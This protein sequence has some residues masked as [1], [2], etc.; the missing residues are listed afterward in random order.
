MSNRKI[1]QQQ[2]SAGTTVDADRL[3]KALQST[4]DYL[5]AIPSGDLLTRYTQTQIVAGWTAIQSAANKNQAPWLRVYNGSNDTEGAGTIAHPWRIK[6]TGQQGSAWA[7]TGDL[8]QWVWTTSIYCEKPCVLDALDM[9]WQTYT[10]VD[11]TTNV[12]PQ[13]TFGN[14]TGGLLC[15]VTIA[16]PQA[17]EEPIASSMVV[18]LRQLYM[19]AEQLGTDT[20][21]FPASTD[22][23]LPVAPVSGMPSNPATQSVTELWLQR[24]DMQKHIPANSRVSFTVVIQNNGVAPLDYES[25]MRGAPNLVVTLLEPIET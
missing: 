19:P 1:T 5:N 23:M 20:T 4:A 9:M 22:N 7:T 8:T 16:D 2:F 18:Q 10:G 15:Q 24:R 3:D 17:T 11:T 6:G 25:Y 12:L 14:S 13:L 21:L